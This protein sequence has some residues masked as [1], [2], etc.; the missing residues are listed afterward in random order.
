MQILPEALQPLAAFAQFVLYKLVPGEE[1]TKKL[2][3]NPHTLQSFAKG[4]DWQTKPERW[5]DAETALLLA[6]SLGDE[7]GVGFLFTEN[8]PFFFLDIDKCT[9]ATGAWSALSQQLCGL[10]NGAAIEISQSGTGLHVFGTYRHIAPHKAKNVP[11]GLE[12]Y[13]E[14]RFVALTGA[15]IVGHASADCTDAL[16]GLIEAYFPKVVSRSTV[17]GWT[18]QPVEGYTCEDDDAALIERACASK[19]ATA[20]L[21]PN[22]VTFADLW[23]GNVEALA[24]K[25][26][27][28]AGR[29]YEMSEADGS[30]AMMLAFWT[31]GNCERIERLMRQ[32]AL[33]R[34]KWSPEVHATYLR[35][36]IQNAVAAQTSFYSVEAPIDTK[37]LDEYGAVNLK[38]SE[39]QVALAEQVRA[40]MLANASPEAAGLLA[41]QAS[42]KFW[43]DN[44]N[45]SPERVAQKVT[46]LATVPQGSRRLTPEVVTG[47]QFLSADMQLEFFKGCV[48]VRE[49][50]KIAVPGGHR[51]AKEPFNATYGGYVFQLD[52]TGNKTTRKAWEAFTESQ[53]IRWPIADSVCFRPALPPNSLVEID[54]LLQLN[55]YVPIK[56]R[57]V[58]GD[59]T[60]FLQ[61]LAKLLPDERDQTIVLSYMAAC[62]QHIGCKF[63]W[64]PLIQGVEGN[65]KTLFSRCVEAAV[66][67][68]YT[69]WP[70]ANQVDDQ[71]NEWMF[72]NVFIGVEDVYYPDSKREIIETLKPMITN[73]RQPK[74]AMQRAQV[75]EWCCAN[76][77]FN[78]NHRDGIRKTRND[79]RF[80]V[81]YCAQQQDDDLKRDGL[82]DEYFVNLYAWLRGDGYA[83]V[84]NFLDTYQIPAEFNP[85]VAAG[86]LAARAPFTS[87]LEQAVAEGMGAAEQAV[88]E[89]IEEG[90]RGFAGG[91]VSSMALASLLKDLRKENAIPPRK[92]REFMQGLGYDYHPALN[93]GRVNNPTAIDGGKTR[94]YIQHGH[95]AQNLQSCVEI[96]SAYEKAQTGAQLD[97]V[98][99]KLL[100]Q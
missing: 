50:N 76:F 82:T 54:D 37:P 31:G 23:E 24:R 28:A 25:W 7:Y 34:E 51:L 96:V 68:R 20:A 97:P 12:L 36:T 78:S 99:K 87:S 10:L 69:H 91:W 14:R 85:A 11:L 93:D 2:P 39:R 57:R 8:D 83:I 21:D 5:T 86:G 75:T 80:A 13:H 41:Q 17:E 67:E 15:G 90:R 53:C 55:T 27:S 95:L 62:V 79:R 40:E 98:A 48:Y 81:F 1:K 44:R 19:P 63:Q 6:N 60:P 35:D 32:S 61:H 74:R 70:K 71:F 46:P 72:C 47:Y 89:A 38:G 3:I 45:E 65:G 18:T 56:T 43:L 77:I 49:E 30:L 16:A 88:V 64:A 59:P 33:V 94:L 66:G 22:L 4:D 73:D 29:A 84:A 42:A 58:A 9:D 26:P 52:E 100:T 92:R